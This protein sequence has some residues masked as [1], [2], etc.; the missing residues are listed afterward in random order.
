VLD[1]SHERKGFFQETLPAIKDNK[2]SCSV[3]HYI[4]HAFCT[5]IGLRFSLFFEKNPV[6]CEMFF[7][8]VR[9]KIPEWSDAVC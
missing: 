5:K 8:P 6:H 1:Q 9:K 4:W 7:G 2:Q 3:A